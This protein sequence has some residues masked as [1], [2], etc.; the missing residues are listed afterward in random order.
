MGMGWHTKCGCPGPQDLRSSKSWLH[1]VRNVLVLLW[2]HNNIDLTPDLER[3]LLFRLRDCRSE[4]GT[5]GK[6]SLYPQPI[7]D[8]LQIGDN[9]IIWSGTTPWLCIPR[10]DFC[11][12]VK[13]G[14]WSAHV[15]PC[16]WQTIAGVSGMHGGTHAFC[17]MYWFELLVIWTPTTI[18]DSIPVHGPSVAHVVHERLVQV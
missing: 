3:R 13:K 6:L 11:F 16:P 4:H 12:S 1:T 17:S 10:S 2:L 18:S 15:F 8:F 14:Y 7:R 5:Y 9:S